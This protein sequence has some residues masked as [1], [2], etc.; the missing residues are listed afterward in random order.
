[1]GYEQVHDPSALFPPTDPVDGRA[2][3]L[4]EVCVMAERV[5]KRATFRS[6]LQAEADSIDRELYGLIRRVDALAER[7]PVAGPK[8]RRAADKLYDARPILR[9]FMHKDDLEITA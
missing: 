4:I 1:M 2:G 5:S 9:G 6:A 8:L 7:I 3:L